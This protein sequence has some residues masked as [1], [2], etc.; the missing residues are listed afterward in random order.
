MLHFSESYVG[1]FFGFARTY[2]AVARFEVQ[3]IESVESEWSEAL[4][5]IVQWR[6]RRGVSATTIQFDLQAD[7]AVIDKVVEILKE[8]LLI[9]RPALAPELQGLLV[10]ASVCIGLEIDPYLHMILYP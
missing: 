7:P 3:S 1:G 6:S 2:G 5:Q 8:R 10:E 9:P 4:R